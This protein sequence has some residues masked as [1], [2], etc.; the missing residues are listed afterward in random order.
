MDFAVP[1]KSVSLDAVSSFARAIGRLMIF[2]ALGEMIGTYVTRDLAA[3]EIETMTL[4]RPAADIAY[5]LADGHNGWSVRLDNLRF[6]IDAVTQTNR[7]GAFSVGNVAADSYVAI[8]SHPLGITQTSP[9]SSGHSV[10]VGDGQAVQGVDFGFAVPALTLNVNR[11]EVFENTGANAATA[12]IRRSNVPSLTSPLVV[13]LS[14]SDATEL[15][16]PTTV[17]I[18]ANSNQ[19]SF[20]VGAVDDTILDGPQVV[21]ISA[22]AS[23]IPPYLDVEPDDFL[24]PVD[25]LTVIAY[26]NAHVAAV[27]EGL[28][29][30]GWRT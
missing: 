12:T 26:I 23:V 20:A 19:V 27:G 22:A 25:V 13:T 5:A 6:S 15:S 14:N 24:G 29:E 16:V 2:N 18:P 28:S 11:S 7:F 1:V 9:S 8:A 21:T 30:Q 3:G 17:T 10:V 4:S